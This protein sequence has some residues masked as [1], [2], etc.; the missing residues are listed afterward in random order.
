MIFYSFGLVSISLLNITNPNKFLEI[1]SIVSAIAVLVL[2]VFLSSQRYCERAMMIKNCYIKLDKLYLKAI[3]MEELSD[4]RKIEQIES[5]YANILL[6]VENHSDYDFLSLRYSLRN[7]KN[8]NLPRL[9]F[10][11]F[12]YYYFSKF[13]RILI[14][15][16]IFLLPFI[17]SY[18]WLKVFNYVS[19]N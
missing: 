5:E 2:S 18:I 19:L 16:I 15:I 9:T 4:Q 13:F 7:N 8:T 12:I 1:Y 11:D 6:N 10:F 3:K 17:I 14:T